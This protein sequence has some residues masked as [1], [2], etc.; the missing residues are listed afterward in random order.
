MFFLDGDALPVERS[1]IRW[2]QKIDSCKG[3][4]VEYFARLFYYN[5]M[6]LLKN[7]VI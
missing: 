3:A 6:K 5:I 1:S 4:N 7:R 2:F